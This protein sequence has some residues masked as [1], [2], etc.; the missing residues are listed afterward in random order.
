MSFPIPGAVHEDGVIL[1]NPEI[2]MADTIISDLAGAGNFSEGVDLGGPDI[3][4]GD[5]SISDLGG[6]GL[7]ADGL[8][9]SYPD[10]MLADPYTHLDDVQLMEGGT[11]LWFYA[12]DPGAIETVTE[13]RV[14]PIT[15]P[16]VSTFRPG[17]F[18][19]V[20][21]LLDFRGDPLY[22]R[23]PLEVRFTDL[24]SPV[25]S[26][27]LWD[28]G[29]GTFS[30]LQNPLHVYKK[31]GIYDVLLQVQIGANWYPVL[32][33]EYVVVW[34]GGLKVAN[35]NKC[36]SYGMP[37]QPQQGIAWREFGGPGWVF[38]E[39]RVGIF[40]VFSDVNQR[41]QLITDART[42]KTYRFA[43]RQGPK[44]SGMSKQAVDRKGDQYGEHEIPWEVRF[45]EHTGNRKY[46]Y[47]KHLISHFQVEPENADAANAPGHDDKGYRNAQ[48]LRLRAYVDG[49]LVADDDLK[50]IPINGEPAFTKNVRGKRIMLSLAGTAGELRI[51]GMDTDYTVLDK[52]GLPA[53]RTLE[54]YNYQ[55][56]FGMPLVHFGPGDNKAYNLAT[57]TDAT[58]SVFTGTTG[59]DGNPTS[60]MQFSPASSL[61]APLVEAVTGD[62]TI[63]LGVSA[64]TANV[65]LC[66]LGTATM[67]IL[68]AG[69]TYTL[70]FD[71]NGTVYDQ[72]LRWKGTGWLLLK[73]SRTGQELVVS[74]DG[75]QTTSFLL[76]GLTLYSGNFVIPAGTAKVLYD[77]WVLP[78]RITE[79]AFERYNW[80]IQNNQGQ[81]FLF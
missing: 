5:A 38:P 58:G 33:L 11:E 41:F 2:V 52:R 43:T 31:P 80:D 35:T 69:N 55:E 6:V 57:G 23:A 71:D 42:G 37:N 47:I 28:F 46:L 64:V 26:N 18:I 32:K 59:P 12:L 7:F 4:L 20:G 66:Q 8:P 49:E 36:F 30:L 65:V 53:D 51:T 45:R 67:S 16:Y 19:V 68:R 60:A 17:V 54:Q 29:D 74:E 77:V 44:G 48:E 27:W 73:V 3:E 15:G 61:T 72:V 14:D 75:R 56:E 76:M 24:S 62:F 78:S 63:M 25:V 34:P 9:L 79:A 50:D 13:N 81:G 40:Q 21:K 39:S 22:G 70:R 10:I 1:N